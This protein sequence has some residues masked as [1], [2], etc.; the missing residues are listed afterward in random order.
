MLTEYGGVRVP[1]NDKRLF[2]NRDLAKILLP[3]VLQNVLTITI[4]MA[5]SIMVSGSGE[6]AFAGVSLV[7]SLD[8]LLVSLFTSIAAGGTVVLAQAMGRK[9][10]Q[11]AC[12][13]A[14]QLLYVSTAIAAIISAVLLVLRTPLLTVLF[15]E[16][17]ESVLAS[18]MRYF[19]I[20]LIS[21]PALAIS[22]SAASVF[23]AQGDSMIALKIS[24][25]E[26]ALNV[27]GN[28]ILI[29]GLK[30]GAAGAAIA[31]L[32]SRVIGAVII[33]MIARNPKRYIHLQ[34]IF[35][36]RPN[37]P[38]I[39]SILRI[40]I[41]GGVESSL[42][43]LGKLITS[44]LVSSLGTASI[45][46]NAAAHSI[47]TLQYTT[48]TAVQNTMVAVVGRCVG[49]EEQEQA[50]HYTRKLVGVCYG[51]ITAMA[52]ITCL[53]HKPLLGLYNLSG[54]SFLMAR[55]L[56]FYHGLAASLIW[57][58]AFALPAAF[59]A[60]ND[61]NFVM[62]ASILSMWLCRV[63]LAYILAKESVSVLGLFTIP[64][65]GL[66]ILGVWIAMTI[67]WVLR[68]ILFLWRFFSGKW[69]TKYQRIEKSPM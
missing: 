44:S 3:M 24:L 63:G 59:R 58:I 56:M 7:N 9:D 23:R 20:V 69:L 28:A 48:G 67:D 12:D 2:S 60:A 27:T 47:V 10:Q 16:A 49:A 61:V 32:I 4:G 50:K 31:T 34:D 43:Q 64:G 46:A 33:T 42:F 8:T 14:K 38:L 29:Y 36:Y 40:G 13:G 53:L 62:V 22:S 6:A 45:A 54:E 55:T 17:E 30:M 18:A 21:Y 66:D 11:T 1:M 5:D 52:V 39:K 25:L 57:A 19:S 51:L 37:A 35:R 65:A 68:V 15:G 26:N 41:P